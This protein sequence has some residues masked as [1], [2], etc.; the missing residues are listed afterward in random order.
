MK[1]DWK[2]NYYVKSIPNEDTS[3][4]MDTSKP[5]NLEQLIRLTAT[6]KKKKASIK[7]K[8]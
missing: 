5:L 6:Q 3:K 8:S 7:N 4:F 1:K 2:N